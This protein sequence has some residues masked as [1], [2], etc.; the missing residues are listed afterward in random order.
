MQTIIQIHTMHFVPDL[1]VVCM[2]AQQKWARILL[3]NLRH[4]VHGK[5]IGIFPF[6]SLLKY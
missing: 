3:E 1:T 6:L 5:G 4:T 2:E